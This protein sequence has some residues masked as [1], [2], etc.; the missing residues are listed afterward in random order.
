M[1]ASASQHQCLSR[2]SNP[3]QTSCTCSYTISTCIIK[4]IPGTSRVRICV[5]CP[6]MCCTSDVER[7]MRASAPQNQCRSRESSTI[8]IRGITAPDVK[9]FTCECEGIGVY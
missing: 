4:P 2:E 3:I 6:F 9:A 7:D 5:S 1:R 8:R